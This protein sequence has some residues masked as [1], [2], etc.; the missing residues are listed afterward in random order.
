MTPAIL[1]RRFGEMGI[2]V[3]IS[4]SVMDP[5]LPCQ[6]C[7]WVAVLRPHAASAG[8]VTSAAYSCLREVYI[9]QDTKCARG[10]SYLR[11]F[12]ERYT[13]E[14]RR[15][16]LPSTRVHSRYRRSPKDA[17]VLASPALRPVPRNPFAPRHP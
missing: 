14:L 12:R 1:A 3:A 15:I 11:N 4:F 8:H 10:P 16:N 17:P 7:G 6:P 9:R 5:V 2:S 13:G